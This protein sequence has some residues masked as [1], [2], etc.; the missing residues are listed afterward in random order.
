[1]EANPHT[2]ISFAKLHN[3]IMAPIAK[4]MSV[5]DEVASPFYATPIKKEAVALDF[6]SKMLTPLLDLGDLQGSL[7]FT[8]LS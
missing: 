7:F 4:C 1:M 2:S 6:F 3:S 5:T 8:C